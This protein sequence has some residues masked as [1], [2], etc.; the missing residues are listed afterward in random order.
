[1]KYIVLDLEFNQAFNFKTGK[2]TVLNPK[3]PFE[4]IQIGAFKLNSQ[5]IIEEKFNCF[6]APK[7]YKRIHPIVKSLTGITEEILADT[8]TFPNAYESFISFLGNEEYTLCTWGIDDIKS[9]FRNILYHKCDHEIIL[10]NYINIQALATK[11]LNYD[12]GSSIGLKKAVE[13]L[14]IEQKGDFHDALNDAYYTSKVFQIVHSE[15]MD[16]KI[17]NIDD[18]DT[19]KSLEGK[20]NTR[21]LLKYF[22]KSLERPLTAE[23]AAII[24]TAYK[25]GR[26]GT[27]ETR[28][29]LK[30]K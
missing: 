21:A 18:L 1:M 3:M 9:L 19:K 11:H 8:I 28:T 26:K 7:L 16:V 15:T 25:F 30:N 6:V 12:A 29:G 2:K 10:K 20:V 24:K 4:I 17:F 27:F 14:E 5:F 13:F 22:E 23:E